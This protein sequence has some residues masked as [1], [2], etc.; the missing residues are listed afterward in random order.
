MLLNC[1]ATGIQAFRVLFRMAF[2]A[3]MA[4]SAWHQH[5]GLLCSAMALFTGQAAWASLG[6]HNYK[7]KPG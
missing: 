3:G 4:Q 7:I 2:S 6:K 1:F 5:L